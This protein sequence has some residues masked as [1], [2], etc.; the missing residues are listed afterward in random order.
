MCAYKLRAPENFFECA[1]FTI[2]CSTL[3]GVTPLRPMNK[4]NKLE[5]EASKHMHI[6]TVFYMTFYSMILVKGLTARTDIATGKYYESNK[7]SSFGLAFQLFSGI[8]IIY[9][10]YICSLCKTKYIFKTVKI[11]TEVDVV[12]SKLG[13]KFS[14]SRD[15]IYQIFI[16]GSGISTIIGIA[17]L[18]RWNI[19]HEKLHPIS[20]EIWM[21]F[22]LPLI[23][24]H[25]VSCQLAFTMMAI[26]ERFRM[27]NNQICK[28]RVLHKRRQFIKDNTGKIHLRYT[29]T[30]I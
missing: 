23:L 30:Q 9:T 5:Y 7:V 17:Q 8:I 10:I 1:S 2:T 27:I 25:L 16:F 19:T 22:I 14:Y 3:I 29:V 28:L 20:S 18:Q 26:Q 6:I 12:L 21:V 15:V 11:L 24:V 4:Q 13:Q